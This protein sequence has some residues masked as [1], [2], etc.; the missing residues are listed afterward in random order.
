MLVV[1]PFIPALRSLRTLFQK[2]CSHNSRIPIHSCD[3]DNKR[4]THLADVYTYQAITLSRRS[5]G[6]C[7]ACLWYVAN[8]LLETQ[9]DKHLV[10]MAMCTMLHEPDIL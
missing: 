5:Y 1:L 2:L 3:L 7:E 8:N 9:R 10:A 6:T 4:C